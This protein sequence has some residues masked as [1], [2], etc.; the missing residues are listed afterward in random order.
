MTERSYTIDRTFA[1]PPSTVY[2]AWTDPAHLGWFFSGEPGVTEPTTVDLRVGGQWR[3]HMVLPGGEAYVT[4]GV[5]RELE[6]HQRI[7][8]TW[9]AV[10]GW[11]DLDLDRLDDFPLATIDLR[12]DGD[13]THMTFT[14]SLPAQWT[15]EEVTAAFDTGMRDGWR[16]TIDRLAEQLS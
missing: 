6:P 11:P 8:F 14:F 2:R 7:V 5:Y 1:A 12:P 16:I 15:D 9:G 10:G 13:S 4:G 3:Q